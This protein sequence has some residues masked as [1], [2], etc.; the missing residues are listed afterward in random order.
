MVGCPLDDAN[1]VDS[2]SVYVYNTAGSYV[3]KINP[4]DGAVQYSQFGFSVA[5]SGSVI[6]IGAPFDNGGSTYT[7]RNLWF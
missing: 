4:F 5:V 7:I 1:G 6:L 3:R 2:G